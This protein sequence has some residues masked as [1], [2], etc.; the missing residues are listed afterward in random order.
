MN[1]LDSFY[2]KLLKKYGPQGWWPLFNPKTGRFEYHKNDYSLPKTDA[3]RF[4]II[5]G[6]ILAQN[7]SW[8]NVQ[9]ALMGLKEKDMLNSEAIKKTDEKILASIIKS[10]GY[11][12][13][14]A[15]KLKKFIEFL[16]SKKSVSRQNLLNVWGVGKETVDSILL[17]AFNQPIFVVDAYTRRI[18]S[19]IYKKDFDYDTLQELF[20]KNLKQDQSI[21]KEY[22]ALLV[23][24]AKRVCKKESN[25]QECS[26]KRDCKSCDLLE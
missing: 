17:Y 14:K 22:H 10:S 2:K 6:A 25:C 18:M 16:D 4:E 23:E 24:H 26:L 8:K 19:R 3:Q 5:V 12:N 21:F 15:K 11:H 9:K 1:K 20:M 13:Q 7:T